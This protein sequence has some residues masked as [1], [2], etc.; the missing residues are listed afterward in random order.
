MAVSRL[1]GAWDTEVLQFTRGSPQG[2]PVVPPGYPGWVSWE[3]LASSAG[4]LGGSWGFPAVILGVSQ[5]TSQGAQPGD[6]PGGSVG[7]R[8][9]TPGVSGHA[10]SESGLTS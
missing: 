8:K 5:G 10:G 3:Y 4:T 9:E 6:S 1:F 2:T 7:A